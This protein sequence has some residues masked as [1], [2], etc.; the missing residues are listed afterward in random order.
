MDHASGDGIAVGRD[1]SALRPERGARVRL[2]LTRASHALRSSAIVP[3]VGNGTVVA[4][5]A[6][7]SKN[8]L[9][10]TDDDLSLLELLGP[11]SRWRRARAPVP[12]TTPLPSSRAR[13]SISCRERRVRRCSYRTGV[14]CEK[15]HPGS[16]RLVSGGHE[17]SPALS[18]GV[19]L[20]DVDPSSGS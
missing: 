20:T 3:L 11:R 13:C 19:P 7:Y 8:L 15:E 6:L 12:R 16:R 17:L 5:L 4:V 1:P 14:P 18:N 2:G 10:F 9:A